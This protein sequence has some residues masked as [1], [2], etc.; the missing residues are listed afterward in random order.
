[1]RNLLITDD[2]PE[3]LEMTRDT[4]LKSACLLTDDPS[5]RGNTWHTPDLYQNNT[6]AEIDHAVINTDV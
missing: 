1:M 5:Q 4:D 3:F 6:D 2:S